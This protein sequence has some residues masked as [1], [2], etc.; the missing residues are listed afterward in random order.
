MIHSEKNNTLLVQE[1]LRSG[2]SL[3]DLLNEHKVNYNINKNKVC[4]NYSTLESSILDPIACECRG[5]VL[6]IN[7]FDIIAYP[8]NRFFNYGTVG[9][10]DNI[11]L[12]NVR[13]ED[14]RDGT[15][16][17]VYWDKLDERWYSGTR[18]I[19]EANI[20]VNGYNLSFSNLADIACNEMVINKNQKVSLQDLMNNINFFNDQEAKER[21]FI[22]ELTSPINRVVCD[23]KDTK[24]TL[25]GVRNNISLKE[26]LPEEWI[27]KDLKSLFDIKISERYEFKDPSNAYDEIQNWDPKYREGVVLVDDK[28]NR[29][30]IKSVN[31]NMYNAKKDAFS[32]SPLGTVRNCITA[33]FLG[34]DDDLIGM[35]P[36]YIEETLLK[37]KK[38]I[39][40]ILST[41]TK[42]YNSIKHITDR[43]EFAIEA[44][45]KK[46]FHALINMHYS[47]DFNFSDFIINSYGTKGEKG[48]TFKKSFIDFIF[49]LILEI[50]PSINV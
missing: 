32:S 12:N 13:Y 41:T 20:N 30:K 23:Y 4:L 6:D 16:L 49:K 19:C 28:F 36:S 46:W 24:L 47:D 17:I 14:K 21:T 37:I 39:I 7:T 34:E 35:I 44:K 48:I 27:T 33:I 10:V 15:C 45:N 40:I 11:D 38:A 18:S 3:E 50:D 1:F 22:F 29:A 31:Y 5:L 43:K 2:K 25:I 26:E 9:I 42:D 8:F